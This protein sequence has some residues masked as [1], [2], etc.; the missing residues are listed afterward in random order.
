[1]RA[2][3]NLARRLLAR[4]H[5]SLLERRR[6]RL[7]AATYRQKEMLSPGPYYSLAAFDYYRCIFVHIPK[8]G[9]ISVSRGLFGNYAGGHYDVQWYQ[10]HYTAAT[11][12][13]YFKFCVVRNPW[14]R[15]RS[16][17]LFLSQGGFHEED[18]RWFEE[19]IGY[20]VGLSEF[21]ESWLSEDNVRSGSIHFRPQVEFIRDSS[22]KI[23]MDFIAR[24]ES[25]SNDFET[26][27]RSIGS[28]RPLPHLNP[29][30]VPEGPGEL[31]TPEAA[32]IVESV[33]SEDIAE[34]GYTAP[35]RLIAA[36]THASRSEDA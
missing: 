11:F 23:A 26:I 19:N 31:F 16:A 17:Y 21:V 3:R 6:R 32:A 2:G 8:T 25:L 20:S 22:G 7:N 10:R 35:E 4:A 29:S 14:D 1:M 18:R 33:Y 28:R 34:F 24:F 13:S 36:S 5:A 15:L 30:F 12:R 9:G 27:K